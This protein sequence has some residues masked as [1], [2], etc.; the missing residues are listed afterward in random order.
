MSLIKKNEFMAKIER[1][2]KPV[3]AI[4]SGVLYKDNGYGTGKVLDIMHRCENSISIDTPKGS[5]TIITGVPVIDP[6]TLETFRKNKG[7]KW[8]HIVAIPVTIHSLMYSNKESKFTGRC[9]IVDN[10]I[11]DGRAIMQ[12]FQFDISE[13]SAHYIFFPNLKLDKHDPLFT[14]ACE[15]YVQF[16]N[17]N[18]Q[19]G[20]RPFAIEIGSIYRLANNLHTLTQ[21]GRGITS[22]FMA[23]C[24]SQQ[25]PIENYDSERKELLALRLQGQ[26]TYELSHVENS[27]SKGKRALLL[28]WRKQ[29]PTAYNQFKVEA[30]KP[31]LKRSE[32]FRSNNNEF[33]SFGRKSDFTRSLSGYKQFD[34]ILG[35]TSGT[36]VDSRGFNGAR[37]EESS[38]GGETEEEARRRKVIEFFK[39]I[40][41]ECEG[42]DIRTENARI[43]GKG[44]QEDNK[45]EEKVPAE[46]LLGFR[47]E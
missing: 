23:I 26:N 38:G 11:L 40:G 47:A 34:Y 25:L 41:Q 1:G 30:I 9:F 2:V 4:P 17:T 22:E 29:G 18:F 39:S 28:K 21:I 36:P 3:D 14:N 35:S 33:E 31:R 10:R 13:E 8:V 24:K 44:P 19:E 5:N 37:A 15:I 7:F 32:S 45:V 43:M 6:Q 12:A 46:E 20:A 16:D 27:Y 42:L